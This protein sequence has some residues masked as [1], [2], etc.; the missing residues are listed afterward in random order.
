MKFITFAGLATFAF[1]LRND[2]RTFIRN[3]HHRGL[4]RE[5]SDPVQVVMILVCGTPKEHMTR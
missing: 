3:D 1:A 4:L 5:L 2:V